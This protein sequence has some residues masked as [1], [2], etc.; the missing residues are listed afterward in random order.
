MPGT[1][2]RAYQLAP[3][4]ETMEELRAQLVKDGCPNVDDYLQGALRRELIKLLKTRR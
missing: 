3:Q 2:E 4:C 1:V